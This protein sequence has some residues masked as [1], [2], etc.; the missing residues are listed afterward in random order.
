LA[1]FGMVYAFKS[2]Y[3]AAKS[4]I[5]NLDYD[6]LWKE[7]FLKQLQISL[8]NRTLYNKLSNY[9]FEKIIELLNNENFIIKKLRS[10]DD[11]K[12]IL[13]KVYNNPISSFLHG[14]VF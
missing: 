5:E 10:G 3:Y 11:L 13:K 12:Y 9:H 4:L 2:G 8:N 14:F 6:D 1:G 7:N